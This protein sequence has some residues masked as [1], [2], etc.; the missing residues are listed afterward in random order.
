MTC[1]TR[2][3][4]STWISANLDIRIISSSFVSFVVSLISS[5]PPRRPLRITRPISF[6]CS[7]SDLVKH[8]S[9]I[10][11]SVVVVRV[12]E[13]AVSRVLSPSCLYNT[14]SCSFVG[15]LRLLLEVWNIKSPLHHCDCILPE[16]RSTV[17]VFNVIVRNYWSLRTNCR[18]QKT[19]NML[20]VLRVGEPETL[21][22]RSNKQLSWLYVAEKGSIKKGWF[23]IVKSR[24]KE[25][26]LKAWLISLFFLFW[27]P[28]S[29][30]GH[31]W[32]QTRFIN[33]RN[34]IHSFP[35]MP[36]AIHI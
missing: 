2:P 31:C 26:S 7:T 13:V 15:I 33:E 24:M 20:S 17:H 8:R 32:S 22:F 4:K 19:R 1:S 16:E 29:L 27:E 5:S 9:L 6:V 28:R 10:I 25:E 11:P 35:R 3:L 21:D 36:M 12:A 23:F 18:G 34:Q 14:N 30:L